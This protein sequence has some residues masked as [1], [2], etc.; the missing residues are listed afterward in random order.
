MSKKLALAIAAS[1]LAAMGG[2]AQ[3]QSNTITFNGEVVETTCDPVVTG[4]NYTVTLDQVA[5]SALIASGP[6]RYSALSVPFSIQ[7]VNC[8]ASVS[9]VG[10][11]LD[12]STYDAANF[13]LNDLTTYGSNAVQIQVMDGTDPTT[14]VEVGAA[15]PVTYV[16]TVSNAASIPMTAHYF[17]KDVANV[18]T[19]K[20]KTTAVYALRTQ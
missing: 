12:S 5:K 14:Q 17:V 1:C 4:G 10:A 18:V 20:I 19:G 3:A 16:S 9:K 11:V 15:D 13:N 8:P 6:G 2:L 7:V